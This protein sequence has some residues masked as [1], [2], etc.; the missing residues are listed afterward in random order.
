MTAPSRDH[1]AADLNAAQRALDDLARER[2]GA[3]SYDALRAQLAA[4]TAER[5]AERA[6]NAPLR[7]LVASL[8]SQRSITRDIVSSTTGQGAAKTLAALDEARRDAATWNARATELEAERDALAKQL[9]GARSMAETFLSATVN[10]AA[11]DD[12]LALTELRAAAGAHLAMEDALDSARARVEDYEASGRKCAGAEW[13]TA[14]D[15][16][17]DAKACASDARA[18]LRALLPTVTP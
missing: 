16:L 13:E 4:V 12:S 9:R 7:A 2:A 8:E 14:A 1:G 10:L 17:D 11:S 5:D 18:A 6:R 15:A 3:P